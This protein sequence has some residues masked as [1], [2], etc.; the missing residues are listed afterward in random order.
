MKIK[1]SLFL[2]IT[3]LIIASCGSDSKN[4]P[5][6]NFDACSCATVQ[7][8]NSEDYKKCKEFRSDAKFEADYHRCKLAAASGI[9]DTSMITLQKAS[10]AT[11]LK[12]AEAGSYSV[13]GSN[14]KITWYGEK[15]TGKKHNG[16]IG[17]RSGTLTITDGKLSGEI[18]LDMT[19]IVVDDQ[20][21][22]SKTKL[23][24]HL[25]SD[26]FF[27][28]A[29]FNDAKYVITSSV[30]T[31][32]I[33]YDVKGNLTLKGITKEV[34]CNLVI[35]PNTND[36][37]ISGGFMFDRSQFDVRYG[38]DKFFDNLGDNM[39]RNEVVMVLD[40]KGKRN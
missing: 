23:E 37:N 36:V 32:A 2:A 19:S 26:D 33:Q 21:G 18:V 6:K 17:M 29:K 16:T 9:K 27:S 12:S 35:T 10:E 1:F 22:E 24:N 15:I 28:T 39:I 5:L 31:N 7:D 30:A 38:S 25:K 11:N 14:S 20:T 40:L 4:S 8:M 34:P 3:C 13:T